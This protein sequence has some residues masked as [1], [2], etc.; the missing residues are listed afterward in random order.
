MLVL[1]FRSCLL[2]GYV[3]EACEEKYRNGYS[4]K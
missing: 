1:L 4:L 3:V 2:L